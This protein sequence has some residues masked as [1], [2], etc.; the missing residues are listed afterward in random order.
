[1]THFASVI[2]GALAR[3]PRQRKKKYRSEPRS[4]V[5]ELT[6]VIL[7]NTRW[8]CWGHAQQPPFEP[9]LDIFKPVGGSIICVRYTSILPPL[10]LSESFHCNKK[11]GSIFI[12]SFIGYLSSLGHLSQPLVAISWL[13]VCHSKRT[14]SSIPISLHCV[15][16]Y[17]HVCVCRAS[18]LVK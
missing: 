3:N 17:I 5:M 10:E 1:M 9:K 4:A 15:Y 7:S 14:H 6:S 18:V 11:R 13:V 16:I 12:D 8:R 2:L